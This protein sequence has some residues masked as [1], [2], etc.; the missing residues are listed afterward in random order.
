MTRDWWKLEAPAYPLSRP[1]ENW[2]RSD[3]EKFLV[4][5]VETRNQLGVLREVPSLP[6]WETNRNHT[7]KDGTKPGMSSVDYESTATIQNE[8]R[9]CQ[10]GRKMDTSWI[11]QGPKMRKSRNI[12]TTPLEFPTDFS[13]KYT[14]QSEPDEESTRSWTLRSW[15]SN[16]TGGICFLPSDRYRNSHQFPSSKRKQQD[17]RVK[18]CTEL[19]VRK[20]YTTKLSPSV[21]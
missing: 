1:N 5:P 2:T 15:K 16:G 3:T 13:G 12:P 18:S 14:Y 8:P 17:E 10:M 19:K 9:Q 6:W 20:Y 7:Q 4:C 21:F 11:S